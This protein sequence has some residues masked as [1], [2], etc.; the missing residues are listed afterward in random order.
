MLGACA[1]PARAPEGEGRTGSPPNVV[2]I[3]ADDLGFGDPG[4]YGTGSRVPTPHMDR[5]AAEGLRLTDAH[6]P[7]AVCTPTR[8]GVLTGRYAW[9]TRLKSGV[10]DGSSPALIPPGT[11]TIPSILA[12]RGYRSA[13]IGKWHL[14][15]GDAHPTDYDAPLSPGPLEVGFDSFF[16]VPASLDMEPYAFVVDHGIEGALDGEVEGSA[17]R[18]RNG[19]G[20]WR[21]GRIATGFSHEGCLPRLTD[22]A[23]AFVEDAAAGEAPFFLYFPMTAPHTPWVPTEEF[24]GASGAGWYGDFV[25]MVDASIGR[26]LAALDEAGLAE[27]TLVL[28]TSDNG[29]HWP[30]ADVATFG[31]DANGGLRGQKADI[32]EGGHR[33]P[34]LVRWPGR[35]PAGGTS[36]APWVHTDLLPTIAHAAGAP[37]PGG[38]WE[39]GVDQ[40][41]TWTDGAPAPR[42]A[43]VMHAFDGTF[44]VRRGPWK[45]ITA[46]GSHGFTPPKQV[47]PE[48]GGPRGQL[49]H[50]GRDPAETENLWLSEPER[51]AELEELLANLRGDA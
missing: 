26:V 17:H 2:L 15:L 21:A 24:H 10:L 36:D 46:L 39:D 29:A 33:V 40:L 16:G 6:T 4:C 47:A 49:Y 50:L 37:R 23:V 11:V 20:F 51:V 14:G 27:D 18:R 7:S 41:A 32:W 28:V 19:G 13:C 38:A 45:L 35:I 31:H 12:E 42:D 22:E 3:L 25:A 5:L 43:F 44:A 48:E 34:F 9:R 30:D 1:G 8:Y